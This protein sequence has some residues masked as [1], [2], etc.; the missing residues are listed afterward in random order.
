MRDGEDGA[1]EGESGVVR[2]ITEMELAL[3]FF[4]TG[5]SSSLFVTFGGRACA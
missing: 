1:E 5:I 3:A 2:M 4:E